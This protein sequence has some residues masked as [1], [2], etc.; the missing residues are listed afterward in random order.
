[1]RGQKLVEQISKWSL[2]S[3]LGTPYY[4]HDGGLTA[5]HSEAVIANIQIH[6]LSVNKA[7]F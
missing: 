6:I 3:S 5:E 1:M 7:S 4:H 2:H